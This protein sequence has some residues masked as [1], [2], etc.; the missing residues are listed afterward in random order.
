VQS[1]AL[2]GVVSLQLW[3]VDE[4][5]AVDLGGGIAR[6]HSRCNER[7]SLI[8]WSSLSVMRSQRSMRFRMGCSHSPVP[9]SSTALSSI[10]IWSWARRAN[11]RAH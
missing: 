10:L 4:K 1:K 6:S 7:T 2:E 5:A 11:R 3:E 8:Q 9:R